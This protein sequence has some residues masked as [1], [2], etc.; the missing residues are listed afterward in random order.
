M[1]APKD[2]SQDFLRQLVRKPSVCL[3]ICRPHF[4][5]ARTFCDEAAGGLQVAVYLDPWPLLRPAFQAG[6]TR[7]T[8]DLSGARFHFRR[9]FELL[10]SAT[11]PE[12]KRRPTVPRAS[13]R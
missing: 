11:R 5:Q 13:R 12:A 9:A 1:S 2:T 10:R 8:P 6:T 4:G 3:V 7:G